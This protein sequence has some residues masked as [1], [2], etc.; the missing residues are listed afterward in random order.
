LGIESFS[1]FSNPWEAWGYAVQGVNRTSFAPG[2]WPGLAV[3]IVSLVFFP[4]FLAGAGWIVYRVWASARAQ[5]FAAHLQ[6]A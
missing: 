5:G 3:A 1:Y 6:R 2:I 4:L